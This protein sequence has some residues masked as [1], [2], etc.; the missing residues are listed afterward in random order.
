[1]RV[2][3]LI[4]LTTTAI[5]TPTLAAA[6]PVS[7]F[8]AGFTGSGAA[9]VAAAT[10]SAIGGLTAV[11]YALG[12]FLG[13][14]ILG[15]LLLNVGIAYLLRPDQPE[16]PRIEQAQVN[17]RIAQA[18]RYQL[19]GRV[20]IGGAAGAF[21][22][23]DSGGNFWY[24]VIH[25]DAELVGEPQYYLD[26]IP[27][28]LQQYDQRIGTAVDQVFTTNLVL[29][30]ML[31]STSREDGDRVL[32][33]GQT[34]ARENGT[35]ELD[36]TGLTDGSGTPFFSLSRA[37]DMA[38]GASVERGLLIPPPSAF[39]GFGGGLSAGRWEL[40]TDVVVG[41]DDVEFVLTDPWSD[42]L[43]AGSVITDE[44]CWNDDAEIWD[45]N[46]E[47][48]L[49]YH[50]FTVSPTADQPYGDLPEWFT[51]SFPALPEDF[52]L[53]GVCYSIVRCASIR[54]PALSRMR[55]FRGPIGIGEPAV[56]LVAN[57]SR[58]PDPRV[59]GVDVS[60][61]S[62]WLPGDGN[63][64]ILWAWWRLNRWGR[65]Q[66][67]TLI[68][69]DMVAA[70]ADD[71]DDI[72]TDRNGDT[73]PRYR[74]GVAI[75]DTQT[76]HEG[77]QEILKAMDAFVAYDDQ[78]RAYPVPGKYRAPTLSLTAARDIFTAAT[79]GVDDGEQ[80]MDGVVVNY[81]SPDHSYT[82][83]PCAPWQNPD[84]YDPAREPNF[85]IVDVLACQSHNQA[86]RLAK[87]IGG[88]EQA[89]FRA[90][91]GTTVKGIL[92][93]RERAIDLTYDAVFDGPHEIVGPVEEG[94]DGAACTMAVVPLAPDRWT[95][96]AGEE[97][98]PPAPTPELEI[99]DGLPDA[100][101]V[102]LT[103]QAIQTDSGQAV[104]MRAVFD[105]PARDDLFFRFR[106]APTGT[107]AHEYFTVDMDELQAY[108]A[109][110]ADGTTYDV[111]WKTVT[112]SGSKGTEWSD[113]ETITVTANATPPA[114]LVSASATG[115]TGEADLAWTAA[116]DGNMRAVEIRRGLTTTYADATLV[117]TVITP[118]NANGT[119]TE[120][121]LAPGTV[122][123]WLTPINGSG[124]P[125]TASGPIT[126]TI[127]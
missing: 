20:K 25:G 69:W 105:A 122:Y 5:I 120:A 41:T 53:A 26:G 55:R 106:Y 49:A 93:K 27:V 52:F 121:G 60:D 13:Q 29:S 14:N 59:E 24:V 81:L 92:A 100:T 58:V 28:E 6:D 91:L 95:L 61:P 86:V 90:A 88:R 114:A 125:G 51:E 117:G 118:A 34:D 75:P 48:R 107:F 77:E 40:T 83:Q 82:K 74:A 110:V 19:G 111:Q 12:A 23:Y 4:L 109:L 42:A 127:S 87:A 50:V 76:R 99:D 89:R 9:G 54:Q 3:R 80:P 119:L 65:A 36:A 79:Q 15:T 57:F 72:L 101:G 78:G 85:L 102:V 16:P 45:N 35:Y 67:H 31:A 56:Q 32:L 2:M 64:A 123:Y 63:P 37:S 47:K 43:R 126:T 98:A 71:C 103:S 115:G 17:T 66:D 1:M 112:S 104:R 68:N 22:E 30:G 33:T 8:I 70:A 73:V 11:G 18:E 84:F 38:S 94:A 10:A 21:A 44:F 39:G 113:I 7:A 97:G 62:T 108:S 116:N 96:N 46:G 124:I